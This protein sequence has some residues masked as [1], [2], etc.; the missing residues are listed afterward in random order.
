MWNKE[1]KKKNNFYE[2]KSLTGTFRTLK[3][4][5]LVYHIIFCFVNK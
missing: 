4:L 1:K 2:I 5:L 3:K